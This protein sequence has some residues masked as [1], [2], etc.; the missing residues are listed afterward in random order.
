[1]ESNVG[2]SM[3][4]RGDRYCGKSSGGWGIGLE[5]G[6]DDLLYLR[7]RT[8]RMMVGYRAP[9]SLVAGCRKIITMNRPDSQDPL[10][11]SLLDRLIDRDPDVSSEPARMRG[12]SLQSYKSSVLRDVEA[13]LNSRKGRPHLDQ[14]F[15][16]LRQSVLTFGLPD[17]TSILAD[18][19]DETSFLCQAVEQAIATF[20]PRL[21][22]VQVKIR[23]IEGKGDRKLRMEI[24]A[25]LWIDPEPMPITFDTIVKPLSGECTVSR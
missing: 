4:Q 21:R 8:A 15:K 19:Q 17:F 6:C 23:D 2:G 9:F 22:E 11:P 12:Q 25:L 13:L 3:S 20:E 1:M 16:E 18:S 14:C 24:S 10:R 7:A 5:V